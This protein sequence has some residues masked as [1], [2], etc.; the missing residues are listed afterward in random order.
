MEVSSR[1]DSA[2]CSRAS[3]PHTPNIRGVKLLSVR[4][5]GRLRLERLVMPSTQQRSSLRGFRASNLFSL[6]VDVP[7]HLTVPRP[8]I[9]ARRLVCFTNLPLFFLIPAALLLLLRDG[10]RGTDRHYCSRL[11]L[12]RRQAAQDKD[13]DNCGGGGSGVSWHYQG[14]LGRVCPIRR[15]VL[16]LTEVAVGS[17]V[18]GE[19]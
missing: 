13:E 19:E 4:E 7:P 8:R 17:S 6:K 14:R 15:V 18:A 11:W 2:R 10:I 12:P 5:L 9:P 1:V 16:L 3:P